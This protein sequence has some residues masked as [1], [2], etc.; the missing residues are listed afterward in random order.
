MIITSLKLS[1]NSDVGYCTMKLYIRQRF[2][3]WY[4]SGES[5]EMGIQYFLHSLEIFSLCIYIYVYIM[6]EW[7]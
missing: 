6:C 5:D 4:N 7:G 2:S 3:G 1:V